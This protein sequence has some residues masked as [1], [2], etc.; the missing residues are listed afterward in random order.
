M[1]LRSKGSKGSLEPNGDDGEALGVEAAWGSLFGWV[2]R[3]RSSG[4]VLK[5]SG[6][7]LSDW[8]SEME[9]LT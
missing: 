2:F 6:S 1:A 3:R 9:R 8:S 7:E 5:F 4:L